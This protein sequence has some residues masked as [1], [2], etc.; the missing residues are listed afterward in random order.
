ML[1][2]LDALASHLSCLAALAVLLAAEAGAAPFDHSWTVLPHDPAVLAVQ[3]E[4]LVEIA[5]RERGE[6]AAKHNIIAWVF[7]TDKGV[8]SDT[9]Y[10]TRLTEAGARLAPAARARR[11]VL[12]SS[13]L[14]DYLDLRVRAEYLTQVTQ[15][16]ARVRHVSRWLNAAS[17]AATP[18]ALR[19]LAALPNVAQL[20]PVARSQRVPLPES[21]PPSPR[22]A[23]SGHLLDYG[24]SEGQL[25]EIQVTNAHDL[26][27]SG[28]GVIVAMLDT[29]YFKDHETFDDI[30]ADGRLL[31]ERDFINGDFQTQDEPS[32]STSQHG[33]GTVTWSALGGT[34][35]G[36][37]YGPAYGAT[38]ALA[39][40]EDVSDEQ[41]IE[42][43][44]WV[45]ASEWADSLGADIISSSLGYF[46][47]Y[48]Y[49]DM[50]GNTAVTTNAAD[51]AASRNILVATAAGNLGAMPWHFIVAPAD[52]DSVL[53]C[54]AVDS[55]NAVAGFS[56]RGPTFDGRIKPEVCARGRFTYCAN[57]GGTT[58]YGSSSGTSLSTP[59]VGGA[60][61][62]VL[63]AHPTWSAMLVRQ[64]L[65]QTA[66]TAGNPDNDRGY[67]RIRVLDAIDFSAVAVAEESA[68]PLAALLRVS[69]NPLAFPGTIELG[70]PSAGPVVV[71][72]YDAGGRAVARLITGTLGAGTHR[73]A[74]DG[75]D[76][77][78]RRLAAGV[79]VLR[80]T[81]IGWDARAKLVV[82]R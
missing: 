66:D 40:T 18:A 74:W 31:A 44:H 56:S 4:Q 34:S 51:I 9:E 2:L 53:A 72:I 45:A 20:L 46:D 52:A 36:E 37:L 80:A 77:T 48:T 6:P 61:A 25:N 43:D 38:F 8:R 12:G 10:A 32:D 26:G 62:L 55:M 49:E 14:V 28:A 16:G 50:D 17:V 63:E 24:P 42:E 19:R 3:A 54:G 7:F 21:L 41:P 5:A 58:S 59:L 75:R 60:A 15:A 22:A 67:G 68:P 78:D 79:Y 70:V 11:A 57:A 82:T 39:K 69:P 64:V 47:W 29:G 33:H 35:P 73:L 27:Y 65:M 71:A 76:G 30:L 1:R 81:G 13:I 23:A